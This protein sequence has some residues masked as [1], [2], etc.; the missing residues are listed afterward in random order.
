MTSIHLLYCLYFA[1]ICL[2]YFTVN[3]RDNYETKRKFWKRKKTAFVHVTHVLEG[4]LV[5]ILKT[6][7]KA[8]GSWSKDRRKF[9]TLSRDE[10]K[11]QQ[12]FYTMI[13][14]KNSY[15]N[16]FTVN[17]LCLEMSSPQNI[18][19]D[20]SWRKFLSFSVP[21]NCFVLE[22]STAIRGGKLTTGKTSIDIF[23][24]VFSL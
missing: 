5:I 16:L 3:P 10:H 21:Q 2:L 17:H 11:K 6:S 13:P 8:C 9:E 24:K 12:K 18:I 1:V 23:L 20:L 4:F 14:E 15:S 19:L 7:A 22:Y